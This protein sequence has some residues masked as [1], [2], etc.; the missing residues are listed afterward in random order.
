MEVLQA[1]ISGV[2][3]NYKEHQEEWCGISA[4]IRARDGRFIAYLN[5]T[6]P[7]ASTSR[8]QLIARTPELISAAQE[9]AALIA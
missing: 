1:R 3:Y 8:E 5:V 2:A 4:S 6:L 7:S 9:I